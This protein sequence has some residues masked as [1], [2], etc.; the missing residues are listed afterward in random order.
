MTMVSSRRSLLLRCP[1]RHEDYHSIVLIMQFTANYQ[2]ASINN[3]NKELTLPCELCTRWSNVSSVA[4]RPS[5][6]A[7]TFSNLRRLRNSGKLRVRVEWLDCSDGAT[8]TELHP[9][10]L[11]Q[12]VSPVLIARRSLPNLA[13]H[14]A[15]IR[16]T[17]EVLTHHI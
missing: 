12:V 11:R 4:N 9:I 7:F 10:L 5:G 17:R 13:T 3:G 8:T 14:F 16:R 15:S 6:P 2:A 1:S